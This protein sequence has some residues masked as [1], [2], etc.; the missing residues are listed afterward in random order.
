[1]SA[2]NRR[3][4]IVLA[5]MLL[6]GPPAWAR[7]AGEG[8][9]NPAWLSEELERIRARHR[10]PALAASLV[11]GDMVVAASAV[12]HRKLGDTTPVAPSDRFCVGSV[13][14]AMTATLVGVMVDKGVLSFDTTMEQM[15]PELV[16]QMQPSYRK[17]T[18]R[19]LLSH[20]S[21]MPGGPKQ[22][23]PRKATPDDLD[24][25]MAHR[26]E[27]VRKTVAE[28]PVGA[29]GKTQHYGSTCVIVVSYL[30]RKLHKPYEEL[31]GQHVFR[32][33]GMT[34]AGKFL[35]NSGPDKL[36][37][38]WPHDRKD[39]RYGPTGL[40]VGRGFSRAPAAGVC[41]SIGDLGRWASAHLRG[42]NGHSNLLRR[43]TFRELHGLQAGVK[44]TMAFTRG[45]PGWA[46]AE[47]LAI[48]GAHVG[49]S[50]QVAI[51]PEHN[52]AICVA[53]NCNGKD[54]DEARREARDF[55]A[56]RV[57]AMR[58]KR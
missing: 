13:T 6:A 14:K 57:K 1:M 22:P 35:M 36:D 49:L 50:A 54:A 51:V 43:K 40:L 48:A 21:G 2:M 20:T 10:L 23:E 32:P 4:V 44:A 34:T 9:A 27:F 45:R 53:T 18:V 25:A 8:V 17:A 41:C 16:E 15:F 39:G 42:E 12:G 26:Y 28:P 30:E 5:G 47:V 55:L 29:P 52:Y 56:R 3:I 58:P 31:M 38:P 37:S 46:G 11:I 33:L 7:P 24:R 19:M